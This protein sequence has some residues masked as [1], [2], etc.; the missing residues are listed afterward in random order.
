M[1]AFHFVAFFALIRFTKLFK[2]SKS[3]VFQFC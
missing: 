3:V 2:F 1:G